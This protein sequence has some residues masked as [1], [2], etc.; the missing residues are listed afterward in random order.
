MSLLSFFLSL[1]RNS[2]T[3]S[4]RHKWRPKRKRLARL[5]LE[6]LEPRWLPSHVTWTGAGGDSNWGNAANWSTGA[7]PGS[8]DDVLIPGGFTVVHSGGTDSIISLN[9]SSPFSL[10]GGTLT[11]A[12]T[13]EDSSTF[14][15]SGGT[16]NGANV[17]LGTTITAISSGATL[18]GVTLDGT[19]TATGNNFVVIVSGLTLN[20]TLT[21]G[22]STT[23]YG[24]YLYFQGTQTLGGSGSVVFGSSSSYNALVGSSGTI[25]TIGSGITVH[26]LDGSIGYDP[27]L[28]TFPLT[29]VN[30]GTISADVGGGTLYLGGTYQGGTFSSA[31]GGVLSI[32]NAT[33]DGV[34]LN[35]AVTI[36]GNHNAIIENGLTLNG[37]VTLGDNGGFGYL[38]FEGTQTLGGSGAVTFGSQSVFNALLATS[39][40]LTIGSGITIGGQTG[41]VGYS[42]EVVGGPNNGTI[43]NQGTIEAN[44]GGG[45]IYLDPATWSSSGMLRVA[46][47]GT[48]SL[49]GT[50]SNTGAILTLVGSGG[51]FQLSGSIV[52]G[53]VNETEG[54][55][56]L[57]QNGTLD[58]VTLDG[59]GA[60]V[61]NHDL[62]IKDGLTLNATVTLGDS[63]GFGFL[64]FD[65]TQTLSGSGTVT[66]GSQ[67][68][69]NALQIVTGTSSTLTIGS[70]ITING[71]T[72]FVGYDPSLGG[73][74]SDPD[75]I[76]IQG[77]IDADTRGNTITI[78]GPSYSP[79]LVAGIL[80]ATNGGS[81]SCPESLN[82]NGSGTQIVSA[83]S[84]LTV[85]GN[86]LG[87][88]KNSALFNPQ[89]VVTLNGSGN[90]GAP[91][92]FEVMSQDLGNVTTGFRD[93]FAYA[94]LTLGNSTYVQ[95]VDNAVN[96]SGS[97]GPEALYVDTLLVPAGTTLNLNGLHVYARLAQIA[98]TIV[99]GTINP[100]P[101]GGPLI[102]NI[103]AAGNI[104]TAGAADSWTFFGRVNQGV[105]VV[106]N[107]GS[108]AASAP[109]P[110]AL[111]YAQVQIL[112]PSGNILGSAINSQSGA[113]ATL[114]GVTLP[115]DGTYTVRVQAPASQP[116]VTGDYIV[117]AWNAPV[118]KYT[119]NLGQTVTGQLATPYAL[120]NWNFSATA[121]EQIQFDLIN[122]SSSLLQFELT[123]PNG[124]TAFSGLTSSS[125][126]IT[127]PTS[128]NYVLTGLWAAPALGPT[129]AY[130]FQLQ[131]TSVT[132]LALNTSYQGTLA[133]NGQAQLFTVTPTNSSA[134]S[135]VLTDLSSNDQ[136]EVYVSVGS[137]PTRDSYKYKYTATGANQT[138][139]L[140]GQTGTY[141]ILVYNNLVTN[142]G[143]TYTLDVETG[144]F[145]LTRLSPGHVGNTQP[146]TLLVIGLFPL[147]YQ[148]A[149]AYQIQFVSGGGTAYPTLPLYL[150]P[151]SFG[152]GS[153]SSLGS[154]GTTTMAA[155][156]AANSLPAGS[157]SVRITDAVGD[158]QTLANGLTVTAGGVGVLKTSISMPNPI[159]YHSPSVFYV[160]YSN[161]GTAPMPAPLLVVTGTQNG[162][163]GAFLSLDASLA[164]L[165]YVTNVTPAGFGQ[166]VQFLAS[167]AV[168]GILEPGE[169]ATVPVYY[170]G[171]L[172][173]QWDF[174]RPPI[175][176]SV[177]DLETTNSQTIDW[178]SFQA[179]LRPGSINQM[180]W[181]AIYPVLMTELGTTWGQYVQQLDNDAVYLAGIGE[182]TDD[183]SQLL[184]FEIEKANAAYTAQTL[185]SVTAES[186]PA[187]GIELTFVQSFQQSIS[188]R[189]TAGILGF[190]WT[191]NWNI[192]ATTMADGDVAI[193][194]NG[195]S[196]YFSRQ[197]N[198]SF[199]PQ[200]GDEGTTLAVIGGAYLLVE[201]DGTV[202]QFNDNGTL[203]FVEDTHGNRITAGY[204]SQGELVSL[205]DSN[206]ENLALN[207][208]SQGHVSQITDS[209][210]Q[211]ETYGY[212]P[213]G[214][215]LT[216]YTDLYGTTNYTYVTGQSAA[217][218]NALASI[219]NAS[220]TTIN[221]GYDAQGRLIDQHENGGAEN[222]TI[223]Y[224]SPGGYVTTDANGNQT[225]AYFNL[226][227]ATADA[228]DALGNVTRNY[229]DSNLNLTKVIGPGGVIYSYTYDQNGNLLSE[230]DPLGLITS[231]TYNGH[232]D[233]TSYTDA[234]GNTTGY[235]YNSANDLLSITYA[236]GTAQ[237]YAYNPLGEATQFVNANR[238]AIG[239]TYNDQGQVTTET[240][241]DGTS[242]SYAYDVR[243]NLTSAMDAQGN[244]ITF[245]YGS[246]SN[247]DLLT[248]VDYPDGTWLKFSYNVIGQRTQSVDQT[249]F[250]VNYSYDALGRLSELTDGSSNLIVQYTYDNV[251]NLIQKSMGNGARTAYAYDGDGNVL[252]ITNYA[253]ANGP[254]N[255]LD[256]Y[257]YDLLGNV[258]TDT[259]QDGE[260]VYGYD[261]DSQLITAVFTPNSADPDGL[262]A[263]NIQYVYDSAGNRESETLNGVTTTYVVNNVNEYTSSM[264]NGV[265]TGFQ[266]DANGNLIAQSTGGSSVTYS[267]NVLNEM[268]AANGPELS[269]AYSYDPLGNLVSQTIN[270]ATT[271]F[272]V[273][274]TGVGN[275]VAAYDGSGN[276]LTHYTI[277]LGL[278]SQVNT[279]NVAAYYDFSITGSTIGITN[280]AGN[281][282]NRYS[283]LPF[284]ATTTG[285]AA[286]VN[287]FTY[288]G[289]FGI[290]TSANGQF[291]MRARVYDS[292][293]G[294]FASN[295]PLGL[296]SGDGNIRRY[297][298]NN[299]ISAIDM[300][301]LSS[302]D[303][304][305]NSLEGLGVGSGALAFATDYAN[306][307]LYLDG[308]SRFLG[309][310]GIG[311]GGF[312]LVH[313]VA[314]GDYFH[315][316]LDFLG[317]TLSVAALGLAGPEVLVADGIGLGIGI[318]VGL[319]D[320][321]GPDCPCHC[322]PSNP[323]IPPSNA[324]SSTTSSAVTS[325]DPNSM[326]GPSGYG[327]A[328]FVS[329]SG[330]LPYQVNFENSP[331]ATAP[332]QRVDIT[333]LLDPSLD[334]SSFQLTA[335]GFGSTYITIPAGL[336]HY[337]TTVDVTENGQSFEV[338]I[339]LNLNAAT[340]VFTASFQ[341]IDPSTNLPPAS[342][343]TGF[344]PPEDGSGRGSGFVSFT[345]NPKAGFP[346]GT[347][348]TNVADIAFDLGETIATNQMND[349][350]PSQGIDPTKEAR[351]TIDSGL[352][353]SCVNPL[354]AVTATTAF[355][356]S[357]SGM[358]DSG[359]SGIS[360]YTIY[361]SDNSS[362]FT[363]WLIDT[364][365]TSGTYVGKGGHT[366][367][368]FSVATDNVGNQQSLPT[369][370]QATT[371]I[372]KPVPVITWSN[373]ANIVY[374]TALGGFQLD[375][376]A[377]VAGSFTY[378][379]SDGVTPASGTVLHAGDDQALLATFT[380]TDTADYA[381]ATATAFINVAKATPVLNWNTPAG[382]GYGTPLSAIQLDATANA[383]GILSY[384][385]TNDMT[386]AN[387]A[388][389]NAGDN[390]TLNVAFTPTD[391]VDYNDA[392]GSVTITVLK[393]TPTV[394]AGSTV[395]YNGNP[396]A[397]VGSATGVGT[398]DPT[399]TG[400]FAFVYS[401]NGYGPTTTPPTASG[402]YTVAVTFTSTDPN[403]TG[404]TGVGSIT[405]NPNWSVNSTTT[406]KSLQVI[407]TGSIVLATFFAQT[408]QSQQS[409]T[410]SVNWQDGSTTT[411]GVSVSGNVVSINGTHT[412]AISGQ[413]F[414]AIT[415]TY[416]NGAVF[417]I[418]AIATVN[419]ATNVTS[420]VN[421]TKTAAT[422]LIAGIYKGLFES[423]VTISNPSNGAA[424][425]G[426]LE[427]ALI[428]LGRSAL[429]TALVYLNGSYQPVPVFYDSANDP[430]IFISKTLLSSLAAG[431]SLQIALY[432]NTA[433]VAYSSQLFD[434][435]YDS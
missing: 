73:S 329:D 40:T 68:I 434:D 418:N 109:Q 324:S 312:S 308:A 354:P 194:D 96:S 19:L 283:Y 313:D 18:E 16:L 172:T 42:P 326:D 338:L 284:G 111:N 26:G 112:D 261:A 135:I 123:G 399:P 415:L 431:N 55:E 311:L 293:T 380:P 327:A 396:N 9:S 158:F 300:T 306:K 412:Y 387:G 294:Q 23:G 321:F 223:T 279:S 435:K 113:D 346:T 355:T 6:Q 71:K 165:A 278:V 266:Y 10:S 192:F 174:S 77:T 169:S 356:V 130:A 322:P 161:I 227:G 375:A 351:V 253:S 397:A 340:G 220:G 58:G 216:S 32:L 379:L 15:L 392:V 138:L 320:Q 214:Q 233:L 157:Y 39:S 384:M 218:D 105:A 115:A 179:G 341:S 314:S 97:T 107:T 54:A 426:S 156:L 350:D 275:V 178:S 106:V 141:Y 236:N 433:P 160:K 21:L 359:G 120:D 168:P 263:Q 317:I 427:L 124:Y 134:L 38:N 295:D 419:V 70:G 153:G 303:A 400:S 226:F 30:D 1:G 67:N 357:W 292:S 364:A 182:P 173:S 154:D 241:P 407:S 151:T 43:V 201:P 368:F 199:A 28:N 175:I 126:L 367:D 316:G 232:N 41:Y 162:L 114:V 136:N 353:T 8:S 144:P 131:E 230:T 82:V 319:Y 282:V 118:N 258:L 164:G 127:L 259:S 290:Q 336:E 46:H 281:Y 72:G 133:G 299:P 205:T 378:T 394:S 203:N 200:A 252:S 286:L 110:P 348:I 45:V 237:Q 296:L 382:I 376:T 185:T 260:W 84:S 231:F 430:V 401:S 87:S 94:T 360:F 166:T 373:P 369:S 333:D 31:D 257:S 212:D 25:L 140:P 95:L 85:S 197:P 207:Y 37:T 188:G 11:V 27:T 147:A 272:Q 402:T 176:F 345:V 186:L 332:A 268:T 410:A 204:N 129:G 240:F 116:S 362:P 198:G 52:G 121:N 388:V 189:Y 228:I 132:D 325:Q 334:W 163:Q 217:K 102:L 33:L 393:A 422:R 76:I 177:G 75:E 24:G 304:F 277:G 243:G 211:T 343:L 389:L 181:N 64:Y 371:F 90:S 262:T 318:G 119:L 246:P 309:G 92:L 51:T 344:L 221:F 193:D 81:I 408:G 404:G 288:I 238:Q 271:S 411:G 372:M 65:G 57:F 235:A 428:G 148:S 416:S 250:T 302:C 413:Y 60:V 61:G 100:L 390:Q 190:G 342:L 122:S 381:S 234:K 44:G 297:A 187:P 155:A 276:L 183:L 36:D 406:T 104:K 145:I 86:L 91:Q 143:N 331:T 66:F 386:P 202:Y 29:I 244:V 210:G 370:A 13:V 159:A 195:I 229:Y 35:A 69:N 78:G 423:T 59:A 310:F 171:W 79:L 184:S 99:G 93:N 323:P 287:P 349:E 289:Q 22:D 366:Y 48:L 254:V 150:S 80:S 47:G 358:D 395:T 298:H 139:V 417:T 374:G 49:Q 101:S 5:R 352:P 103:A 305:N 403:Y 365:Q 53:T 219:T 146:A 377:S 273:D 280:A 285:A 89:G 385:L 307:Y 391:T 196:V 361:V 420:S 424:I 3:S 224:L 2:N 213:T 128:G 56:L 180:A 142:P 20:G 251:G 267:F 4:G 88:T 34:T 398:A 215:F 117:T 14:T 12:A 247:P 270:G 255:S 63:S 222:E 405:I 50:C 264:T 245:I 315:A 209:N 421:V 363:P 347:Q 291:L 330:A 125:G 432:F 225:T 256:D 7:L 301:G 265:T 425:T 152:I 108:Q 328:N 167:G 17:L 409:F 269:A 249:G 248:E 242:Y 274:P 170:G 339:F 62:L 429:N 208:N 83:I 414:P 239:Y 335:V 98:G 74:S 337:D 383:A 191:T 137:A 206:G 149:S